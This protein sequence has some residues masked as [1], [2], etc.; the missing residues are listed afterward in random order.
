MNY[1][2]YAYKN[3]SDY[4]N[5]DI[6]AMQEQISTLKEEIKRRKQLQKKRTP[7]LYED[8]VRSFMK[9]FV[10]LPENE[11]KEVIE[12][13][14]QPDEQNLAELKTTSAP[15][16]KKQRK[17]REKQV[18][19]EPTPIE[20][21]QE[22]EIEPVIELKMTNDSIELREE[23]PEAPPKPK[24]GR[25]RKSDTQKDEEKK[26][27][28]PKRTPKPKL[29]D[30][31]EENFEEDDD[32]ID[33]S[34]ED[35]VY[36]PELYSNIK[37]IPLNSASQEE[38]D[39]PTDQNLP[40]VTPDL[41]EKDVVNDAGACFIT[42]KP[43]FD[44]PEYRNV[45]FPILD[46]RIDVSKLDSGGVLHVF[47]HD[48]TNIPLTEMEQEV[49][50]NI[51]LT[52]SNGLKI[53]AKEIFFPFDQSI[54]DDDPRLRHDLVVIAVEGLRK[55]LYEATNGAIQIEYYIFREDRYSYNEYVPYEAV[56][57][58][59]RKAGPLDSL[60]EKN[61]QSLYESAKKSYS[62]S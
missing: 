59:F 50:Q 44:D 48:Y 15:K 62:G 22:Q 34:N 26:V 45:I 60:Q 38:V 32:E 57:I 36:D 24:R 47:G 21:H 30:V 54:E 37:S 56:S 14:K 4:A 46:D 33:V 23:Q 51:K 1:I 8:A 25:P 42:K 17:S 2:K 49:L 3:A 52:G 13:F 35:S 9:M 43:D 16:A 53:M 28:E 55:K 61:Y 6:E 40:S 18:Q 27:K 31:P 58:R 19:I 5:N 29:D 10:S 41:C 20:S 7:E 12:A 39:A 11:Q